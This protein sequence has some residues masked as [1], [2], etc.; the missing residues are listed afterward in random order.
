MRSLLAV[1]LISLLQPTSVLAELWVPAF[2]SDHMVLQRD[3]MVAI[4]GR[5]TGNSPVTVTF[6]GQ[7]V[8]ATADSAG[9][10]KLQIASGAADAV[11]SSLK[12]ETQPGEPALTL[13]DVL[14]GEVWFASGQSNMVFTMSRVPAYADVIAGSNFPQ[15]RMFNAPMVTAVEPQDRIEGKWSLCT[16][17]S[18]PD[19]SAVA[20]FFARKLHTELNVPVGVIKSA[21]GGKPVETFTSREALLTLPATKSLV[22]AALLADRNFDPARAATSYERQLQQW[23]TKEAEWKQKAASAR[24]ARPR[25]PAAPKRPLASEGQPGVL[26][27]SMIHPFVGY[28]LRGVIWY[29]GE[30]NAKA[31]AVPYDQTLPLMIQDWRT[32][33]NSDLSFYFVQLANFRAASTEPGDRDPWPLLQDRMRKVLQTTPKTGMA[34]C[35]D[36]GEA[37]DIHPKNKLDVGERLALWA[38]AKDYVRADVVYCGPLYRTSVVKGAAIEVQFDQI[39]TGL[40][41]RDSGTLNRFEIAGA[42]KVWHWAQ[43]TITAADTV[44]VSSD[45]V[46]QPV[47]VRYAWAANPSGANLVNSAGLPASVFRTDDWDDVEGQ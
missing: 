34:I 27:N 31:G 24:G 29:Q 26:F 33:W 10:W 32:R 20:F 40:K 7:S 9:R 17:T 4:W 44:V 42:D 39:G 16:P 23:Q 43:A 41:A 21:W 36:I 28:T 46:P 2:F 45:S 37:K 14:V 19:F 38:L 47:A 1:L 35:N 3:S 22:E 13:Q 18:V 25:K 30:A 11:G 12:I 15:I 8:R 6:R 5:A